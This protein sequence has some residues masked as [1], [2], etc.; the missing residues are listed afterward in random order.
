M[1][2]T[3]ERYS[4]SSSSDDI[5]VE[6]GP[7]SIF[8]NLCSAEDPPRSVAICPQRRC[9]AFGCVAGV[10]IHW[11]DILDGQGMTRW[12]P[13]ANTSDYLY[14][15]PPRPDV[16]SVKRLRLTSS[17]AHPSE[18]ARLDARFAPQLQEARE[19]E[20]VWESTSKMAFPGAFPSPEP[21]K[22]DHYRTVPLSDG[23]HALFTDPESGCVCL[24]CLPDVPANNAC[25][26]KRVLLRGPQ[27]ESADEVSLVPKCYAAGPELAW[28]GRIAV[29]YSDGSLWLFSVPADMFLASR[30]DN[31]QWELG[32][33]D[34][35]NRCGSIDE[36]IYI[37][38][39]GTGWIDWPVQ[40]HGVHVADIPGLED[41][42][43]DAS[44]G[45]VTLWAFSNYGLARKWE[46]STG[47]DPEVR[48][49]TVLTDGTIVPAAE[50]DGDW[51]MRNA[52]WV[53]SYASTP[54]GYDGT[55]SSMHQH[56]AW[57]LGSRT[58]MRPGTPDSGYASDEGEP[59]TSVDDRLSLG[60]LTARFRTMKLNDGDSDSDVELRDRTS[61]DNDID[62]GYVSARE[63]RAVSLMDVDGPPTIL[64]GHDYPLELPTPQSEQL[65]QLGR[66]V[67]Q[68]ISHDAA[69]G[70]SYDGIIEQWA[71]SPT[72]L[73]IP[74]RE[75]RWS[76]ESFEE[77]DWTPDYLG[78]K[79]DDEGDEGD[80]GG[81]LDLLD[82]REV[83]FEIL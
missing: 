10:E 4:I 63:S 38:E 35:C 65:T 28:G 17:A 49:S 42:I 29:G 61:I 11:T 69:N 45:S 36:A 83:E 56:P 18:K 40:I 32:W 3:P 41:V 24:G 39:D 20:M 31:E 7:R 51:I 79:D 13:I 80:A 50:D 68:H 81:D 2:N 1:T 27:P 77:H 12:I 71:S 64:D 48:K 16:D 62:E 53:P 46:L 8:R 57:N 70:D 14:F 44:N 21:S 30:S 43:I 22:P 34:E 67:G 6:K 15:L 9:V 54:A 25:L 76:G 26:A 19:D 47:A 66:D 74:C 82:L 78:T 23:Y 60:S 75:K 5:L 59:A 58:T 73:Y 52:P 37:N 72:A 33:V 55:T